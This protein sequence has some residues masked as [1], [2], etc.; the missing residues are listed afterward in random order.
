MYAPNA[1]LKTP[2]LAPIQRRDVADLPP[3]LI[4]TA[5][6]DPLR[7]EGYAYAERLKQARVPVEYRCFAGQIHCLLGLPPQAT[8]LRELDQLITATMGKILRKK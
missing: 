5:E 3:A 2:D 4:I 1:A 7:D 8:E 6:F